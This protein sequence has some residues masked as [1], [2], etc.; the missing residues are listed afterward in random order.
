MKT[1]IDFEFQFFDVRDIAAQSWKNGGGKTQE[2]IS[3]PQGS[4]WSNFLARVSI[5]QI[6][7]SGPFSVFEGVDRVIC[8]LKGD[9]VVLHHA[10]Q[11]SHHLNQTLTP[12][13]FRGEEPIDCQ[14]IG[15]SSTDLN[16]MTRRDLV[17]AEMQVIG[18]DQSI[19]LEHNTLYVGIVQAGNWDFHFTHSSGS[20]PLPG[21]LPQQG[22][23]A[24]PVFSNFQ[25]PMLKAQIKSSDTTGLS[26]FILMTIR[27]LS[28]TSTT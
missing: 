4:D 21:G 14:L 6:E 15:Q 22:F 17:K 27:F 9:G 24:L 7:K 1:N 11:L 19:A 5:A 10:N 20:E 25:T 2:I 12:Y 3:F 16:L 8:L 28:L 26:A 23:Y 18:T 13:A